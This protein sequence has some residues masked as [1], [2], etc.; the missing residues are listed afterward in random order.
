MQR[1]TCRSPPLRKS[2]ARRAGG[3]ATRRSRACRRRPQ[4]VLEASPPAGTP[5]RRAT[6]TDPRRRECWGSGR[7]TKA[8]D[9]DACT[10]HCARRPRHPI[11]AT[12]R[13]RSR[14]E[15][16]VRNLGAVMCRRVEPNARERGARVDGRAPGAVAESRG[17]SLIPPARRAG[18]AHPGAGGR[19]RRDCAESLYACMMHAMPEV[20][21]MG[22]APSHPRSSARACARRATPSSTS[23]AR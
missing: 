14:R 18:C 8:R 22:V 5:S 6:T 12:I 9:C 3:S 11:A 13:L 15:L 17:L 23:A 19:L 2:P 1:A 16:H 4:A 21:L 10:P 20:L 7:K